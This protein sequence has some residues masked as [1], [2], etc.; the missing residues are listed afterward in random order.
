MRDSSNSLANTFKGLKLKF[1]G[2]DPATFKDWRK[3]T[4]LILSINRKDVVGIMKENR[5]PAEGTT[6]TTSMTH[7]STTA[8][9]TLEQAQATYDKASQDLYTILYLL[10]EKPAQLLLK[11]ENKT[12]I[13]GNGHK[14]W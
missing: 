9:H 2:E 7:E 4:F 6:A 8:P 13:G 11:H 12:G 5:R 1:S 3:E 10:T 14:V